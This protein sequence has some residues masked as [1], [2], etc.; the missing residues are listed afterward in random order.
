MPAVL[1]SFTPA[2]VR[3]QDLISPHW[4]AEIESGPHYVEATDTHTNVDDFLVRARAYFRGMGME[5]TT[6]TGYVNYA[7]HAPIKHL[8][9][10][11]NATAAE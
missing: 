9:F 3:G 1:V 2:H 10:S 7:E 6:I 8:N 11:M 5:I 4:L